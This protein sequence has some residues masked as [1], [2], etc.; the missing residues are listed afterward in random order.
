M[1]QKNH[2]AEHSSP[3]PVTPYLSAETKKVQVRNMFDAIAKRYDFLNHFLS[4]GIDR[5]WRNIA[6][7]SL[8][9]HPASLILDVATGTGDFA[10]TLCRFTPAN[11]IGVDISQN[12]LA[13]GQTKVLKARLAHR[14]QLQLADSEDLPFPENHFDAATSAFGV[15][16]FEDLRKGLS[17]VVRILKPGGKVV[18]LEFSEPQGGVFRPLF[19]GYFKYILPLMARCFSPDKQAYH[20][21]PE[22]ALR[23]PSGQTFL[24]IM[25]ECGFCRVQ[26]QTLTWGV[27]SVYSGFKPS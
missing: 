25:D 26:Q 13:I 10:F 16:N 12:M 15:R 20:Y 19:R 8:R 17:E 11:I 1:E 7:R 4:L 14:I 2:P 23:F 9:N 3:S 24:N 6:A 5:M 22:S 18:I 21:L 27:A